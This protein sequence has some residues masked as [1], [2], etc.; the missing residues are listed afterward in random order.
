M[1]KRTIEDRLREEYFE[2]LPEIHRA[3]WQIESEVRFYTRDICLSL[4]NPEQLIIKSRVKD[5]ESALSSLQRACRREGQEFDPEDPDAYSLRQLPDLAGIRILVFPN[6][7][8]HEVDAILRIHFA[9]LSAKPIKNHKREVLAPR[10]FGYCDN[11]GGS[12]RVSVEYRVV[13]MLLGLLWEVEHS[14]MY[15]FKAVAASKEMRKRRS[16]VEKALAHFEEGVERF[17]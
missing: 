8:V 16:E 12:K 11:R 14:A 4:N 9:D 10:Y 15:K 6:K 1:Q 5:C 17:L 7:R 13:P 2:L 3:V